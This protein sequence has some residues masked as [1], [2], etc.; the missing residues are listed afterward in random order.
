[1]GMV[2]HIVEE[3]PEDSL[4]YALAH[5]IPQSETKIKQTE[6]VDIEALD[7]L[8]ETMHCGCDIDVTSSPFW[9]EILLVPMSEQRIDDSII[10]DNDLRKIEPQIIKCFQPDDPEATISQLKQL[11]ASKSNSSS[12]A[13]AEETLQK[14]ESLHKKNKK[15]LKNWYN[16]TTMAASPDTSLADVCEAELK[17]LY[18]EA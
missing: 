4:A 17:T 6:P 13:W 5:T 14:M 15:A 16:L 3:G 7:D 12:L 1:M 8:L 9:D 18:T 10:A 11:V 2:T